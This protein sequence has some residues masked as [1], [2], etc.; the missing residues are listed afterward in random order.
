MSKI[1]IYDTTLRDGS[2]TEGIS[3]SASDKVKIAKKLDLLGVHYIE[4]GWPGSNPKD[5]EF[6]EVMAKTKLKNSVIAA[7]GSTRRAKIKCSD[8]VNLCELIK[9]KAKTLTI[10]G[11]TWDMH[12]TDVIKCSLEENLRMIEESVA[13]LKK[14]KREVFYDAE[15]FFD[16][17]KNNPEYAL[18]TLL[19]AQEGGAACLVLCDTNGGTTPSE[20]RQIIGEIQHKVD[21]PLGIHP[22][23]DLGLAV[24]NCLAA[25][26]MGCVQVQGT[27][28]GLGERC[29]NADLGTLVGILSTK[30]GVK[31][32]PDS[33]LKLLTETS[34]YL[35]EVSNMKL[36]D[37]HPFVGHSA[38]CP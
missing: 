7:F 20:I 14:K 35:S 13:F 32:I 28:N 34:Y 19:A 10:F 16:G 33:K 30:M 15:H 37:N 18:K 31:V 12:V 21:T 25:I 24:A 27:F 2:Q 22:H 9:S 29:G 11:K 4:G 6:F 3:F 8:D 26:E 17:Y 38:F 36:A 1:V 5:K 23:N